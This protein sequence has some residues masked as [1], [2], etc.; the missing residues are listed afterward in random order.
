M[1]KGLAMVAATAIGCFSSAASAVTFVEVRSG[2]TP[3][4][5]PLFV[6]GILT[7]A[8]F[9]CN[10]SGSSCNAENDQLS[11]GYD[12]NF[13]VD[14]TSFNSDN[15]AI[16]G[17]FSFEDLDQDVLFPRFFTL[18]AGNEFAIFEIEA[19]DYQGTTLFDIAF[20]TADL[21]LQGFDLFGKELSNLAFYDTANPIPLPA[22]AWLLFS[23]I[24]GLGYLGSRSRRRRAPVA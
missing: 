21:D 1:R 22:S 10:V 16:G 20:S 23:A 14:L 18:K 11:A 15:E 5:D 2:N 4:P 19:S 24:G 9:K 8:L 17:T 13:S 3:Y 6:D 7:P 12:D